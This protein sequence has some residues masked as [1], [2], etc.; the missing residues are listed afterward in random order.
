MHLILGMVGLAIQSDLE[1][2]AYH[3]IAGLE[4]GR[5]AILRRSG[6]QPRGNQVVDEWVVVPFLNFM[7]Q[8]VDIGDE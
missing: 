5:A 7:A 3:R 8:P 4:K 6:S 2:K 1:A